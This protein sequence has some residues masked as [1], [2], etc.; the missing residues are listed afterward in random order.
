MQVRI[1]PP[2]DRLVSVPLDANR[3]CIAEVKGRPHA[4][5]CRNEF[6]IWR[7][8]VPGVAIHVSAPALDQVC[9]G[10]REHGLWFTL[11]C[12]GPQQSTSKRVPVRRFQAKRGGSTT[13]H[14]PV[15]GGSAVRI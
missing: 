10:R 1:D 5:Y 15:F 13:P 4:V 8:Y 3:V 7:K 12:L 9:F 6:R 11:R 2:V 14:S